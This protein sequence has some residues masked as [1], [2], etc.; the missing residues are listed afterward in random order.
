MNGYHDDLML[1]SLWDLCQINVISSR[2]QYVGFHVY[3]NNVLLC[4]K[5]IFCNR[6]F[7]HDVSKNV[8]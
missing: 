6:F 3:N 2:L 8:I 1:G 5:L 7:A 4:L